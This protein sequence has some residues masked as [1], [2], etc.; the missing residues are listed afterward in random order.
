[1]G[2]PEFGRRVTFVRRAGGGF[3]VARFT[4]YRNGTA[5]VQE[6][7]NFSTY[8]DSP[9]LW[10]D[11]FSDFRQ[12][13]YTELSEALLAGLLSKQEADHLLQGRP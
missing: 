10:L 11:V 12:Q 3:E 7:G 6:G 13:G 8:G 2:E 4:P 9:G 1:M 5:L